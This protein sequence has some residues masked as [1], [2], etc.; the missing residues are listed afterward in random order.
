MVDHDATKNVPAN[1]PSP[2][3]R[4]ILQRLHGNI[5]LIG[6]IVA[7]VAGIITA[8]T[9]LMPSTGTDL[10]AFCETWRSNVNYNG[11]L[12]GF[13][14]QAT[15]GGSGPSAEQVAQ[16]TNELVSVS[17]RAA[18]HAPSEIHGDVREYARLQNVTSQKLALN[19]YRLDVIPQAEAAEIQQLFA[20]MN[21]KMAKI[22]YWSRSH[23]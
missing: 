10:A 17:D 12:A 7:G 20:N 8:V 15:S 23:C 21:G 13:T 18:A 5:K 16:V 22:E 1:Q 3:K 14:Q 4:G 6:G 11:I 9:T 19:G 2:P